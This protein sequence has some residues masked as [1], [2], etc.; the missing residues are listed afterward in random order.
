MHECFAVGANTGVNNCAGGLLN[1]GWP[2]LVRKIWPGIFVNLWLTTLAQK[3][4]PGMHE[5]FA[6]GAA[7]VLI[8]LPRNNNLSVPGLKSR[9]VVL[10]GS[11]VVRPAAAAGPVAIGAAAAAA[12]ITT[13]PTTAVVAVLASINKG[14]A[15]TAAAKSAG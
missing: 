10:V 1:L 8:E 13:A 14:V 9:A 12:R 11:G 6:V 5:C 4:W 2:K 7:C 15:A 3:I